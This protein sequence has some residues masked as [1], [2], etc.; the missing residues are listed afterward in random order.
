MR[1]FHT[2]AGTEVGPRFD[3]FSGGDRSPHGG[4]LL[5]RHRRR[6]ASEANDRQ[7]AGSIEHTHAFFIFKPAE[8]VRRKQGHYRH[9]DPVGPP[10]PLAKRRRKAS[11][12]FLRTWG[13]TGGCL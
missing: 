10:P 1:N 2:L 9:L 6:T 11:R 12:W 4:N 13:L 5:I 7:N 3:C 8:N